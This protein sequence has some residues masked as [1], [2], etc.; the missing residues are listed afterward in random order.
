MAAAGP[1]SQCRQI[2]MTLRLTFNMA[3]HIGAGISEADNTIH[4]GDSATADA[5]Y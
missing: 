3:K 1:F 4:A 5:T 2:R